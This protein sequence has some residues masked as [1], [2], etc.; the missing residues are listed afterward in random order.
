MD[1]LQERRDKQISSLQNQ[2]RRH[3]KIVDSD[4]ATDKQKSDSNMRLSTIEI[5]MNNVDAEFDR[6]W[7]K[8]RP[9]DK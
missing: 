4:G 3:Q 8:I 7:A 9:N 1:V 2:Y 5:M 6:A